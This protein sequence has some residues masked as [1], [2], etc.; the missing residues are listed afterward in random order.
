MPERIELKKTGAITMR[1]EG[2]HSEAEVRKAMSTIFNPEIA[3]MLPRLEVTRDGE[4]F[5]AR[6]C[7]CSV[8]D[9]MHTCPCDETCY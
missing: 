1:F 3:E 5:S 8:G 7:T 9:E 4:V 2:F 6:T